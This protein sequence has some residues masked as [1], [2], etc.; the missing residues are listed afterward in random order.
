[1]YEQ[2]TRDMA[3]SIGGTYSIDEIGKEHFKR[4]AKEAGLG[5]KMAM[6]HFEAMV[7]HFKSALHESAEE[8]VAAG[9]PKARDLERRILQSGGIMK[10]E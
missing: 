9:D 6:R 10:A 4:A 3:F 2:S 8:L 1:M 5:E 7:G